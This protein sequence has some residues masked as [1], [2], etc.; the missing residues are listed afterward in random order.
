MIINCNVDLLVELLIDGLAYI[1]ATS[2]PSKRKLLELIP[3]VAPQWYELGIQLLRE[4]Q[5]PHLDVIKSDCGND[6][7]RCCV[8]MF[9]YWLKTNPKASWQQLLDALRSPALELCT[10]AANIEAMFTSKCYIHIWNCFS[11]GLIIKI[12]GWP[13]IAA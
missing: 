5:E 10:V 9:W 13:A 2:A 3:S 8:Q 7:K 6:N 4:D 1:S 11:C 12:F